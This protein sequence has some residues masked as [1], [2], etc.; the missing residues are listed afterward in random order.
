MPD[1]SVT[2]IQRFST[3][4]GPGV[5]TTVF[6]QGCPLRCAWCH[7]PETQLAQPQLMYADKLCVSCGMCARVCPQQA[8]RLTGESH[9]IDR[10]KCVS[11]GLC[12]AACPTGGC[13][14]SSR[15]M[16]V[17]EILSAVLADRAFYG[18]SG[19]L[20]LSGGEPMAQPEA[21]LQLLRAAKAAGLHTAV[22]TCGHF[23]KRYVDDAAA[24]TDLFLW[25]WK[26][27]DP[28]LHRQ[29][30]GTDN[31][32]ILRNLLQADALGAAI[33]LRCILVRGVNLSD[34]HLQGIADLYHHLHRARGVTLLPY[35]TFGGSKALQL[36]R[37][38]PSRPEWIP[39]P[40]DVAHAR[41]FLAERGV[42]VLD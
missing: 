20:T 5:R 35:H 9:R 16:P 4:D 29:Y 25:D 22:E 24:C 39:A 14:M 34:D 12:A 17:D 15:R 7:N 11:C 32:L 27:T 8:H 42:P 10:E 40:E 30:T 36:G 3:H 33:E 28:A 13:E 21:A 18:P 1:L 2:R 19:G 38:D 23:A 41:A 26:C 6:T 37:S 31:S